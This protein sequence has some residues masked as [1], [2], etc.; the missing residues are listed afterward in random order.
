MGDPLNFKLRGPLSRQPLILDVMKC[1]RSARRGVG[2]ALLCGDDECRYLTDELFE[3]S[4]GLESVDDDVVVDPG[5]VVDQDITEADGLPDRARKPGGTD[6]VVTEEPDCVAVVRR[7]S[8]AFS[9][10]NMLGHVHAGLDRSDKRV[11]DASEPDGILT[12]VFPGFRFALEYGD[13]V[14][15]AAEQAQDAVLVDH[16]LTCSWP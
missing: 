9:R 1:L 6:P 12:T 2:G 8:P 7:R 13:V 4:Q 16:Q 5:I 10:A 15:N 3:I 14:R 11:L